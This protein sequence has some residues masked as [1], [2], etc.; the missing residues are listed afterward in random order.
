MSRS[1]I[2]RKVISSPAGLITSVGLC[3]GTSQ[4]DVQDFQLERQGQ[5]IMVEGTNDQSEAPMVAPPIL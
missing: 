3:P 1:V 4:V 2:S 5:Q